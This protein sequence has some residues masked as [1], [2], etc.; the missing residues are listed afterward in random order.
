MY[1]YDGVEEFACWL[2]LPQ[3]RRSPRLMASSG[4]IASPPDSRK[5]GILRVAVHGLSLPVDCES[6]G[7]G[8]LADEDVCKELLPYVIVEYGNYQVSV[9]G[10]YRRLGIKGERVN[11]TSQNQKWLGF[12]V[13]TPSDLIVHIIVK[14]HNASG[15][16]QLILIGFAKLNIFSQPLPSHPQSMGLENGCGRIFLKPWYIEKDLPYL[17]DRWEWSWPYL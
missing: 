3:S 10:I 8:N 2:H 11:W 1:E 9:K 17:E 14:K 6:V 15:I 13:S 16:S 4:P 5:P 7:L 12:N